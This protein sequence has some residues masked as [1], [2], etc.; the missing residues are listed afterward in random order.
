M[1]V[2]FSGSLIELQYGAM[3]VTIISQ[4]MEKNFN[5]KDKKFRKSSEI[6]GLS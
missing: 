4:S 3:P 2:L 1:P 6:L 5:F